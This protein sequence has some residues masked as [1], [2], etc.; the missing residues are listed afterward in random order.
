MEKTPGQRTAVVRA[1]VV[2]RVEGARDVDQRVD[3]VARLNPANRARGHVVDV[4]D[5][6]VLP[7][8]S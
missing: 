4:S 5:G 3:A 7:I 6:D 1:V 8:S 2:E